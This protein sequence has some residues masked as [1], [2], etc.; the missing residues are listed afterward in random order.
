MRA[1]QG[2]RNG[3]VLVIVLLVAATGILRDQ[4]AAA[5]MSVLTAFLIFSVGTWLRALSLILV[6]RSH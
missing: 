4:T 5:F 2:L 3:T 6:P 1:L